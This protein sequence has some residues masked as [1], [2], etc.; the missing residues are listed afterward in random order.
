MPFIYATG[1]ASAT[2]HAPTVAVFHPILARS[3]LLRA[4]CRWP[5]ND[6]G[7]AASAQT[8]AARATSVSRDH[9]AGAMKVG[10]TLRPTEL[11]IFGNPQGGTPTAA[12]TA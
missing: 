6:K 10:K 11:L 8:V 5:C 9:A 3:P 4:D 2:L 12:T 7:I 1:V